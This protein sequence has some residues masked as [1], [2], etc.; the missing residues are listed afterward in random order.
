MG[1]IYAGAQTVYVWLG[2]E[3]SSTKH[4]VGWL[5]T[6][7]FVDYCFKDGNV[8]DHLLVRP[9]TWAAIWSYYRTRWSVKRSYAAQRPRDCIGK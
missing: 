6:T 1:D 9:R 7:G 5:S 3:S 8:N 4:V 2:E